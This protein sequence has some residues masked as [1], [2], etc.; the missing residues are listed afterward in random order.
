[1]SAATKAGGFWHAS[2]RLRDHERILRSEG[3]FA[4]PFHFAGRLYLTN[5][6]LIWVPMR[7]LPLIGV[8]LGTA[9]SIELSDVEECTTGKRVF[10]APHRPVYVRTSYGLRDFLIGMRY[11]TLSV[12]EWIDSIQAARSAT[13]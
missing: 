4:S 9:L 11:T 6:R 1:M 12:A 10:G 2:V 7:I 13:R 5:E 8:A 3:A